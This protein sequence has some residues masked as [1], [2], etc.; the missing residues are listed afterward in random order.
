MPSGPVV[1]IIDDEAMVRRSLRR[2]LE[3]D[4]VTVREAED[5][6]AG[7]AALSSDWACDAVLVDLSMPGMGGD[8]VIRRVRAEHPTV[9]TFV[10]SGSLPDEALVALTDG[11]LSKPFDHEQVRAAVRR[12]RRGSTN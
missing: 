9:L 10:L 11:V 2:M 1:L 6:E 4:G 12:P 3:R 5:G 7:L 8:E